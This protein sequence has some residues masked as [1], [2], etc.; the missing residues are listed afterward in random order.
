MFSKY[1][2]AHCNKFTLNSKRKF[3]DHNGKV[4]NRLCKPCA[5]EDDE[6]WDWFRSEQEREQAEWQQF[7]ADEEAK[8]AQQRLDEEL[9]ATMDDYNDD[10]DESD[11]DFDDED[12]YVS[13]TE[14]YNRAYSHFGNAEMAREAAEMYPGDFI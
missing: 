2:C 6:A 13:T 7:V 4:I 3:T 8:M 1:K 11:D 14:V 10:Y 5:V 12:D 9:E